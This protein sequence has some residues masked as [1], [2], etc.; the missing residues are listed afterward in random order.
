MP[1]SKKTKLYMRRMVIATAGLLEL[2]R[3]DVIAFSGLAAKHSNGRESFLMTKRREN[4]PRNQSVFRCG[5]HGPRLPTE[6]F[7]SQFWLSIAMLPR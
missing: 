2:A 6:W 7:S 1:F 4:D 3:Y 5:F